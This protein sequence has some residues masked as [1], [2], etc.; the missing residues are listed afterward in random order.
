MWWLLHYRVSKNEKCRYVSK[1]SNT[2]FIHFLKTAQ[3]IPETGAC[4][5]GKGLSHQIFTYFSLLQYTALHSRYMEKH[6]LSWLL[7]VSLIYMCQVFSTVLHM[8]RNVTKHCPNSA[9]FPGIQVQ[10]KS[11][12]FLTIT[13]FCV[14]SYGGLLIKHHP[15]YY[16]PDYCST[17]FQWL[18]QMCCVIG[19][20]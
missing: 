10:H 13:D 7:K 15:I 1:E 18:Q 9:E 5:R 17:L 12:L 3:S 16:A 19:C 20:I 11:F 14:V 6:L 4:F 2:Y 8:L